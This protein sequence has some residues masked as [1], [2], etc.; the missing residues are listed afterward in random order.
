MISASVMASINR[1]CK[2]SVA[3]GA[4][5]VELVPSGLPQLDGS[6]LYIDVDHG[7][8]SYILGEQELYL[9]DVPSRR[10]HWTP[11]GLPQQE[12]LPL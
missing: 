12:A 5:P 11:A 6:V 2:A 3:Y 8:S 1:T 9:L 4:P 10:T 7:L